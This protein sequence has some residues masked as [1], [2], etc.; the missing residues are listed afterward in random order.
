MMKKQPKRDIVKE[1]KRK[2]TP[3]LKKNGV[4]KAGIF[5]SYAKGTQKR[6]SDIDFLVKFEKGK[7]LFDLVGLKMEL[8]D[9]LKKK[10]DVVT[11]NSLHH[12]IRES[13]LKEEIKIL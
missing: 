9:S 4:V 6:D 5:G 11:Y 8:E 7:S 1:I 10:V 2:A 13:A 3:I 12:L